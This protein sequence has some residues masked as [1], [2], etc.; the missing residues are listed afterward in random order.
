MSDSNNSLTKK[1]RVVAAQKAN[2]RGGRF[3]PAKITFPKRKRSITPDVVVDKE[4]SMKQQSS[5]S[6]KWNSIG[7]GAQPDST[8]RKSEVKSRKRYDGD[9]RASL[10]AKRLPK[11][12]AKPTVLLTASFL[13]VKNLK[14]LLIKKIL[15]VQLLVSLVMKRMV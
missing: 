13:V 8:F 1:Q 10:Y 7:L 12:N 5:D 9:S 4:R 14:K 6:G 3:G 11:F 2:G 15:L